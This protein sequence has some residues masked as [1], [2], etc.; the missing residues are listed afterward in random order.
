MRRVLEGERSVQWV[1]V[2]RQVCAVGLSKET[3]LC[4]GAMGV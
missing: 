2:R 1:C 4:N 3:G